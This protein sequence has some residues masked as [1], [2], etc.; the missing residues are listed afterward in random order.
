MAAAH[1]DYGKDVGNTAGRIQQLGDACANRLATMAGL[2]RVPENSFYS[3]ISNICYAYYRNLNI[4]YHEA[5]DGSAFKRIEKLLLGS[6]S[7]RITS[8]HVASDGAEFDAIQELVYDVVE[9]HTRC[10][11]AVLVACETKIEDCEIT[12]REIVDRYHA[13]NPSNFKL[14][15]DWHRNVK[16]CVE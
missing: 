4:A 13:N 7:D 10:V 2:P 14:R 3:G 12:A 6:D 9:L 15:R 5:K 1:E 16:S 8:I 11:K